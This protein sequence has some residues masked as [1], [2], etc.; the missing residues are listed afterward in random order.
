LILVAQ[1]TTAYGRDIH[2]GYRLAVLLERLAELDSNVWIRFLYGHP[3]SLEQNV[4]DTMVRFPNLCPYFDIPIQ[5][6]ATRMLQRMGRHYTAGD[7]LR[8]FDDIR[9]RVPG[10][11]LRTTVLLGFP[12]ETT[13]DFEQLFQ[14]IDRV[15]FDHLGAFAYSDAADLAS[16][17]L[18]NHVDKTVA[19]GRVEDVMLHQIEISARNLTR[20]RGDRLDVLLESGSQD[21]VWKGRTRFQAPEVDGQV[22]IRAGG[23]KPPMPGTITPVRIVETLEYDLVAEPL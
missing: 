22:L 17:R 2:S 23:A 8:L 18:P 20:Y 1:E 11:V 6:A 19:H 10:A 5:H 7:L 9:D 3:Q 21:D 16:H 14:F 13:N 4:L 12:G 15:Q